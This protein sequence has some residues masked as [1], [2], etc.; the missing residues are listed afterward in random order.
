VALI[1]STH[2]FGQGRQQAHDALRGLGDLNFLLTVIE[3]GHGLGG[4]RAHP[5][6]TDQG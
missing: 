1:Q 4:L 5:N 2:G 3:H 6:S